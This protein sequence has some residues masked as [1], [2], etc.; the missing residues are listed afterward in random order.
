MTRLHAK[1]D[2]RMANGEWRMGI[3]YSLLAI[4]Y[5]RFAEGVSP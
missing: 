5:S 3:R 1:M 4:G 2:A